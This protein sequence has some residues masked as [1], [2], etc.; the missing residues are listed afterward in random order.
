[1]HIG[2]LGAMDA[3]VALL[4]R[5]ME[6]ERTHEAL[7]TTFYTG[8]LMGCPVSVAV[9]GIGKLN[10]ALCTAFMIRELSVEAVV[11]VGIAGAMASNLR[12]MDVV[13]STEVAFHDMEARLAEFVYPFRFNFTADPDLVSLALTAC[14]EIL[15]QKGLRFTS[16]LVAT[17]DQ[18]IA[19]AAQRERI[20]AL[21]S[22]LC[23][24]MEGAAVGQVAAIH[25][26]P[27]V[28]IRTMSD[29]ADDEAE[30]TYANFKEKAADQ[31]AA[32]V[33]R[34]AQ[35]LAAKK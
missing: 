34:I 8:R 25:D 28:V 31:S 3:E 33:M 15:P 24:E 2:I 30:D 6:V 18:F 5:H 9:M 13:V 29:S 21:L 22:P 19:S 1:L 32:I 35:A 14:E 17:G 4:V 11:N 10:A 12:V 27:F 26:V 16:G 7:G 20:Q 23:V